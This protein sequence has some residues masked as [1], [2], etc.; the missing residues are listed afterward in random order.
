MI[1]RVKELSSSALIKDDIF[2][3]YVESIES[4][5]L[6]GTS[7]ICILSIIN[8][9]NGEGAY[10]Y[11][12]LKEL[13]EATGGMLVIEEGTLYPLLKNLEKKGIV[14]STKKQFKGRPR[15]YYHLT[16]SGLKIFNHI[17]GFFSK[18]IESIASLIDIKVVLKEK[19]IYCPQ[20]ANRISLR[21]ETVRFCEVC[22][23]NIEELKRRSL[24]Q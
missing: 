6:R 10:G 13:E 14:E 17:S 23:N 7:T 1:K 20:C 3:N 24:N 11:Q 18:L 22:G 21:D 16:E 19:F 4:E 2:R 15:K 12:I 9:Y 8:K 5:T